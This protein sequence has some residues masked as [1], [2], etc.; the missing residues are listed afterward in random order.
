[1]TNKN[2]IWVWFCL[3][4]AGVFFISALQSCGKSDN[5]SPQGL[6]IQYEVFNLSPDLGPVALFITYNQV[7]APTSP[8]I[9]G[10]NENPSTN[11]FYVP[12][13]DTPY[14][15]KP[16]LANGSA[17]TV[18][19]SRDDI[20]KTGLRYSLFITGTQTNNTLKQIFTID[21]A[22][23]P[24]AGHGKIRFVNA[25]PLTFGGLDLYA[26]GTKAFS[27]INY[28]NY[29]GYIELPVGN[30]NFQVTASGSTAT[31]NQPPPVTIVNGRLYTLY[32]Y[33]YTSRTDSAAFNL[34]VITNQ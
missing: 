6:N 34:G 3:C 33:G 17:G 1:M 5:A 23:T 14:Q 22:A 12:K 8:F 21:T 13:T 15:F 31:L 2:N 28:P 26:N 29:T 32:A 27:T 16:I 30:Y 9:F 11:Y 7:S 10:I 19:F 20:L 24:S 4:V 18:I 25:A